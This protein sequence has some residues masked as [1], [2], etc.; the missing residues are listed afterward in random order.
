MN[1]KLSNNENFNQNTKIINT[2]ERNQRV[3]GLDIIRMIAIL[4]VFVTH[5]IAYKGVINVNQLSFKWTLY[6]IL[7]FLSMTC[8]PLFLL[9]T[10]YL[11]SK[12]EISKKYYK[13]IIPILISYI[14]ISIFEI[15][16]TSIYTQTPIDIKTTIIQILNFTANSYA[17]YFEMY[18]G[19]FL[20][21]PFL[22]ILY[23][24]L[25]SKREKY[26]LVI[27]LVFLTFI[28]Q[29]VKSFKIGDMWLDITPD[30]WQIIYPITYFYIGKLIKEFKPNLSIAKRIIFFMMALAIPCTFCYIFSTETQYAWYI[31]NGFEALTNAITAIAIFLMFYDFNKKT[32]VVNKVITEI[33]ICS[34]EMYL[35]SSI[36]DKFLYS[37]FQYNMIIMLGMVIITTYISAKIFILI[38][39]IVLKYFSKK[40]Y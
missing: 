8:V 35:F 33:S 19:L 16:A 3:L 2:N 30:Y 10:G 34:F 21:I 28:P 25:K 14:C 23:D 11:N 32:P 26:T 7:R 17:W 1:K 5:S 29:I 18:I 13:G 27:S 22:N 40:T 39:D 15:V 4:F 31:F 20:I 12:K 6:M 9:L 24:N 36:W 37:K 38:R